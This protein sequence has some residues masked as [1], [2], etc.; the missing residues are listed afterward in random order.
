MFCKFC[1][2]PSETEVCPNCA[3][4]QA[5][6]QPQYQAQPRTIT[7]GDLAQT[8]NAYLHYVL[9]IFAV[10]AFV[11]GILNLCSVF[12][13]KGVV[14]FDGER[15][16]DYASVSDAA[17]AMDDMDSS[18]ATIYIGN[19]LFGLANLGVAAV[20]ALYFL[21]AQMGMPYYDKYIGK[22][23]KS[24]PMFLMGVLAAAGSA[25]QVIFYMFCR[26]SEKVPVGYSSSGKLKKEKMV[27]SFG[28][29]WTTWVILGFAIGMILLDKFVLEKKKNSAAV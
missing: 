12:H 21:K 23:L 5:P 4:K 24:R 10:A 19:I 28:V 6:A 1:G 16:A 2:A 14:K 9:A 27:F 15:E 13:V 25:L 3:A 18:A 8:V 26:I 11:W 22:P 20:G 17:E 7:A 29:N